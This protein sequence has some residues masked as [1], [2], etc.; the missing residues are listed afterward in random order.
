MATNLA[1][2]VSSCCHIPSNIRLSSSL[3][4]MYKKL[5]WAAFI[6]TH[7]IWYVRR[8]GERYRHHPA[9]DNHCTLG[10][11]ELCCFSKVLTMCSIYGGGIRQ[12]FVQSCSVLY[13]ILIASSCCHMTVSLLLY[14]AVLSQDLLWYATLAQCALINHHIA[15]FSFAIITLSNSREIHKYTQ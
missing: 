2:Y 6:A 5:D 1:T 10:W 14:R 7:L 4:E 3:L 13:G 15:S 12:N 8:I 9:S 11:S